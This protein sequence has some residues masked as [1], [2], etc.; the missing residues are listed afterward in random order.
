MAKKVC[1]KEELPEWSGKVLQGLAYWI[2]Y[3]KQYFKNYPIR[4]GEMVGET[5]KLL[6]SKLDSHYRLDAEVTLK[7]LCA[8]WNKKKE[9]V[10][11]VIS[12]KAKKKEDFDYRSGMH[13]VIEVKRNEAD[14]KEIAKDL[15]RMAKLLSMTDNK[16]VRCFLLFVSQDGRP[17]EYVGKTGRA[18]R[19]NI[20]IDGYDDHVA[21]VRQVKK[22]LDKFYI[23]KKDENNIKRKTYD[24]ADK[25]HYVCLI[26]VVKKCKK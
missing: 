15:K 16:E 21:R 10:D 9:R 23:Y 2:G 26:E 4:E 14:A 8:D 24:I 22:A 6:S 1:M 20:K 18:S 11:I 3:Q 17:D 7:K 13:Y 12:E 5:L 25:A 19:K